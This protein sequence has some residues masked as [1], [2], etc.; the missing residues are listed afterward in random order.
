MGVI[1]GDAKHEGVSCHNQLSIPGVPNR[2][3][4]QSDGKWN[5]MLPL[6]ELETGGRECLKDTW[7]YGAVILHLMNSYLGSESLQCVKGVPSSVTQCRSLIR[8]LSALDIIEK[9][10]VGGTRI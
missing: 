1:S 2:P 9:V 7:G 8:C 6:V 4:G 10:W 3:V 5:V